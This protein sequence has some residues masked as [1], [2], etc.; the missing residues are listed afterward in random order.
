M[1]G[2]NGA[3]FFEALVLRNHGI[4]TARP[5]TPRGEARARKR[6]ARPENQVDF[7]NCMVRRVRRR[8]A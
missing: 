6:I 8:Q 4:V 2:Y 3:I 1:V 7:F 5:V